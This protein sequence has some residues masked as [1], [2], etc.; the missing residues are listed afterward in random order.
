[1]LLKLRMLRSLPTIIKNI[2]KRPNFLAYK[3]LQGRIPKYRSLIP[4]FGMKQVILV[5]ILEMFVVNFGIV[6]IFSAIFYLLDIFLKAESWSA[7]SVSLLGLFNLPNFDTSVLENVNFKV[8]DNYMQSDIAKVDTP[9]V[10]VWKIHTITKWFISYLT[11][12]ASN[13]WMDHEYWQTVYNN[14]EGIKHYLYPLTIGISITSLI[15]WDFIYIS[16]KVVGYI[17]F[18]LIPETQLGKNIIFLLGKLLGTPLGFIKYYFVNI[19]PETFIGGYVIKILNNIVISPLNELVKYITR[20]LFGDD[21][22]G[23]DTI[24]S[25]AKDFTDRVKVIN[26]SQD[27]PVGPQPEFVEG[28]S[29]ALLKK[30]IETSYS[31]YK[32]KGKAINLSKDELLSILERSEEVKI[33]LEDSRTKSPVENEALE[34]NNQWQDSNVE[35]ER[36]ELFGYETTNSTDNVSEAD[37]DTTIKETINLRDGLINPKYDFIPTVEEPHLPAIEP[38]STILVMHYCFLLGACASTAFIL[39]SGINYVILN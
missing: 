22:D 4:S 27:N 6:F 35:S 15:I 32:G 14:S 24:K 20:K 7:L 30:P 12:L 5:W 25:I 36:A 17:I 21:D 29:N 23:G 8:L 9:D 33:D 13:Y 16:G 37:S 26:N 39:Y 31:S 1:M 34:V 38:S 11:I 19:F 10:P 18:E 2:L 3:D 28:N